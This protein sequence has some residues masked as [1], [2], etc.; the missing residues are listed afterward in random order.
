MQKPKIPKACRK[1]ARYA[2]LKNL[3]RISFYIVY[4]LIWILGYAFYLQYPINK[5]FVWWVELIFASLVLLSGWLIFKMTAFVC[6][7]SFLGRI[8]LMKVSR[9]YGRGITREGKFKVDFHTYRVLT[10]RDKK[11]RKRKLKFQLFDDGYDLYYREGGEIAYFR[12]TTYPLSLD[13][14]DG[15]GDICVI[16]GVRSY[17]E[18]RDGKRGEKPEKCSVCG[19]ELVREYELTGR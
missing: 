9:N 3:K 16:C 13:S 11:G 7:R 14:D 15:S 10:V 5:P 4:I 12:G 19:R 8:E 6:E 1:T 2:A 17:P 18:L